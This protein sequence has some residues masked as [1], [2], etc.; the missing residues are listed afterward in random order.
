MRDLCPARSQSISLCDALDRVLDTGVVVLGEVT[1][2]VAEIDLIYVGLQLVVTSIENGRDHATDRLPNRGSPRGIRATGTQ[3]D[4]GGFIPRGGPSGSDAR[5]VRTAPPEAPHA[6]AQKALTV[7]PP[8]S[9]ASAAEGSP[10][11]TASGLDRTPRQN[12][13]QGL[14]QLVLTVIKLLHD[15]L[16]RQ[17]LRRM[18]RGAL[19]AAQIERLGVTLLRQAQEIEK[20]RQ[21]LGLQDEEL[22]LDLGPLGKLL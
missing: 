6:E 17:A 3:P 8:L 2:S 21:E 5:Y 4:G 22:N 15:L 10:P 16:E 18:E 13:A 20:L 7:R 9:A 1:L 11:A 12:A 19:D 14:G